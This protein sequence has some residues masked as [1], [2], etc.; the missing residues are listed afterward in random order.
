MDLNNVGIFLRVAE[1]KSFT[2][3]A[4]DLRL[5]PSSVSKHIQELENELGATLLVRSTRRLSLTE[6][7]EA[8]Y[9][10]C[11]SAIGEL[12]QAQSAISS[13]YGQPAGTL[14]VSAALGFGETVITPLIPHFLAENPNLRLSLKLNAE[15]VNLVEEGMDVV[16]RAGPELDTRLE[17]RELVPIAHRIC[18]SPAFLEQHGRPEHPRDLERF[19]C[20]THPVYAAKIW[21]FQEGGR[22]LAVRVNGCYEVNSS[23]AL[24]KAALAGL[25]IVRI[26]G[27]IVHDDLA[28]GRLVALFEAS[29]VTTQ[30]MRAFY[31]RA[32][33]LPAKIPVFLDF[34]DRKIRQ[35]NR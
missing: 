17:Y 3:A 14:R 24:R 19:N 35:A 12:D 10:R 2:L 15:R 16:I 9:E 31:A 11:T 25:G 29:T 5:S 4:R 18:A 8:F 20:L 7:G 6:A 21:N 1:R 34:L 26:P 32:K 33:H 22:D 28:A 30:M 23:E 13:L 27:Y